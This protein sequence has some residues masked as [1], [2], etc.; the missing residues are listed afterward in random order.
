MTNAKIRA[1]TTAAPGDIG[2]AIDHE[3][4]A[5]RLAEQIAHAAAIA[6]HGAGGTASNPVSRS[7]AA[8]D[9][10]RPIWADEH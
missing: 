10:P 8:T 5:D 7:G 9:E 3:L 4:L 6:A 1:V 2:A